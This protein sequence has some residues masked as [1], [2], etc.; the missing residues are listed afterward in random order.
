[1][2]KVLLVV[3]EKGYTW[4]EVIYPYLE[5]Q[6]QGWDI[7]FATPAGGAPKVDPVSVIVRPVLQMFGY[8]TAKSVAPESV[9]GKELLSRMEH[10]ISLDQADATDYD[11]IFVAGGHGALFDLNKNEALHQLLLEFDEAKKPLGLL[12][13]ASSALAFMEKNGKP[14][15]Q[16]RRITGFP[17]AWE[18]GVLKTNSV[19]KDFLPLPLWTGKEIEKAATGRTWLDRIGEV[20]NPWYTIQDK[21]VIT[22]VGPKTGAKLARLVTQYE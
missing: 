8:G 14:Y 15:L 20:V 1:M 4:D 7:V 17:T 11:A 22:G 18:H 21:N 13:H 12:C 16:G 3:S 19:H 9:K 6:K 2:K 10:P 5:F